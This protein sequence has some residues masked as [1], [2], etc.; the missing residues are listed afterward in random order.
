MKQL[1]VLFSLLFI[2]NTA[3]ADYWRHGFHGRW[4]P[5]ITSW[6]APAIVGGVIGYELSRPAYTTPQTVY[7]EPPVAYAQPMLQ[8][9]TPV[10]YHWEQILDAN[11]NCYKTVLV[12]NY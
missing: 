8:P 2:T 12:S 1:L 7:V 11:C 4:S 3:S 10:G 9:R 5:P 6:V